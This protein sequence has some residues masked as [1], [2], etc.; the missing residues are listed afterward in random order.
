V[1][2]LELDKLVTGVTLIRNK[3]D[4]RIEKE[5]SDYFEKEDVVR[6]EG[7]VA[8]DHPRA[9]L[10]N[11]VGNEV[12]LLV[13]LVHVDDSIQGVVVDRNCLLFAKSDWPS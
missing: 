9:L 10:G 4:E 2:L 7:S 1:L 13:S 11:V 3:V 12:L 5:M 8:G 6:K